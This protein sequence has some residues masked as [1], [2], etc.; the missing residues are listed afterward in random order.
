[1]SV[2]VIV[3]CF[4]SEA[5]LPRCLDS[6]L[7][8]NISGIEIICIDD[9]ST[10]GTSEVLKQYADKYP[11]LIRYKRQENAGACAARN[12]GLRLAT[13]TYV[14]FLDADDELAEGKITHQL[15][16]AALNNNPDLIAG[17]Y[18]S[19]SEGNGEEIVEVFGQD[20]WIALIRGRLG[21]TCSNLFLRNAVQVIS[22]WNEKMQSSQE[23]E[24]MFRMLKN[25]ATCITDQEVLTI[26]HLRS[27]GSIS[28]KDPEGNLERYFMLRVEISDYLQSCSQYTLERARHLSAI[29][30]G[31]LAMLYK[32]NKSRAVALYTEYYAGK[33][34]P[35]ALSPVSR[36]RSVLYRTLGFRFTVQLFLLLGK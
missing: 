29:L 24:L 6:V 23:G 5:F 20:S 30:L 8:Q 31:T 9:G 33:F 7:A 27:S 18:R 19:R 3:P 2:S 15:Q 14:Q 35:V 25:G 28:R 12:H 34:T 21:C 1:M 36:L 11:S 32:V 22:G 17:A 4:N 10:D 26:V 16:L 13:G